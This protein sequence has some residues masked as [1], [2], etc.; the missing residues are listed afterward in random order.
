MSTVNRIN[1]YYI[2]IYLEKSTKEKLSHII[3][4]ITMNKQYKT[5]KKAEHF[6]NT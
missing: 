4:T 2:Y 5:L 1:N 3:I 6:N